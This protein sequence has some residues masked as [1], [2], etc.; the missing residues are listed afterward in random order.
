M[1][2]TASDKMFTVLRTALA[3]ATI[4]YMGAFQGIALIL[5]FNYLYDSMM[6]HIFGL[7]SLYPVDSVFNYD[8]ENNISNIVSKLMWIKNCC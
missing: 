1:K 6:W 7:E 4:Y 5:M 8:D 2:F 3:V